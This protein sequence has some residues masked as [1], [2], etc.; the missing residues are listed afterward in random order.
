MQRVL[1]SVVIGLA[2]SPLSLAV[3]QSSQSAAASSSS[4][5]TITFSAAVMQTNEAQKSFAAL[6]Q[7]YAPREAQLKSLNDEVDTLK[8]QLDTLG[9]NLSDGERQQRAVTIDTKQKQLQRE[10]DE[11]KSDSQEDTQEAFQAVAQKLYPFL[12][13]YAQQKHYTMVVERGSVDNPIVWY[14]EASTD[15]TSDVVRA[16]NAQSGAPALPSAP[17]KA[18]AAAKTPPPGL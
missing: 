11:Y 6:K 5:V 15:I 9:A 8:K 18:P 3:A 2:I 1:M 4:I 7:K 14:A 17:A 12:Q 13:T 16:Y 10:A